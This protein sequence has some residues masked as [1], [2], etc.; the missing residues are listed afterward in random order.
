MQSLSEFIGQAP[1]IFTAAPALN[2]NLLV[3]SEVLVAVPLNDQRMDPFAA[4]TE[5]EK[6]VTL[7]VVVPT[8]TV[9]V[10][11]VVIVTLQ[12]EGSW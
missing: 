10:V 7:I 6:P 8:G 9:M 4:C 1:T 11:G 12:V 2:V 5:P 3:M